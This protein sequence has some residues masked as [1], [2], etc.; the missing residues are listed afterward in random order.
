MYTSMPECIRVCQDVYEYARMYTSMPGRILIY[1]IQ[2]NVIQ[3]ILYIM[4]YCYIYIY[5]KCPIYPSLLSASAGIYIYIY[6]Y[7]LQNVYSWE[8][9]SGLPCFEVGYPNGLTIWLPALHYI[10]IYIYSIKLYYIIYKD[11]SWHTRIHPGILVYI[12]AYSYT[13]WHT[14][15]HPGILV[16]VLAYSYN[17]I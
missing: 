7:M 17:L 16:Y 13:S 12:L 3:Y 1:L 11:T 8:L 4:L 6:I 5:I 14:P 9:Y 15:I 2:Y 10:Y